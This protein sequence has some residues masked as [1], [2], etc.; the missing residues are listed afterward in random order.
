MELAS[1]IAGVLFANEILDATIA[2]NSTYSI[3]DA[4]V[5]DAFRDIEFAKRIKDGVGGQDENKVKTKKG[6]TQDKEN[7]AGTD[8][9]KSNADGESHG[10]TLELDS[11]STLTYADDPETV[12][13]H[14]FTR[15]SL[16]D[17]FRDKIDRRN[18]AF[19]IPTIHW[20][21]VQLDPDQMYCLPFKFVDSLVDNKTCNNPHTGIMVVS[22][23][24]GR[25]DL[26]CKCKYPD[27]W[28]GPHCDR[29]M[30]CITTTHY[31]VSTYFPIWDYLKN[32]EVVSYDG[33]FDIRQRMPDGTA[34][35]RCKCSNAYTMRYTTAIHPLHCLPDPCFPTLTNQ[36][37]SSAKGLNPVTMKCEC[38]PDLTAIGGDTACVRLESNL[39][40]ITPH[41]VRKDVDSVKLPRYGSLCTARNEIPYFAFDGNGASELAGIE[42]YANEILDRWRWYTCVNPCQDCDEIKR[43][44]K[45]VAGLGVGSTA[46][47]MRQLM[48]AVPKLENESICT[49]SP[50][51]FGI[52]T[53]NPNYSPGDSKDPT[54]VIT[55]E[56]KANPAVNYN[57]GDGYPKRFPVGYAY[58]WGD[59]YDTVLNPLSSKRCMQ[60]RDLNELSFP[61]RYFSKL[62]TWLC[63]PLD[64]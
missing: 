43:G 13:T 46:N 23:E 9:T 54:R 3:N 5:S 49:S 25:L 38:G 64:L 35:I 22:Y 31:G 63:P 33:S 40:K 50:G 7:K 48:Y 12:C 52:C 62:D 36:P 55:C 44:I 16:R 59:M 14:G 56:T 19:V 4:M 29:Q 34:R 37:P 27:L 10:P 21:R 24:N 53:V 60:H 41:D 6:K 1:G 51:R 17:I 42:Y 58:K 32:K 2:N 11:M 26:S 47:D 28:G 30:C 39:V 57:E 45:Y 18:G 8:G 61:I 20:N 15:T